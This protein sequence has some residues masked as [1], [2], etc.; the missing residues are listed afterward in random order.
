LAAAIG[1]WPISSVQPFSAPSEEII[2]A[3]PSTAPAHGP[4]IAVAASENG[5]G[6]FIRLSRGRTPITATVPST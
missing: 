2:T 4:H 6:E 3:M 1:T 5:A